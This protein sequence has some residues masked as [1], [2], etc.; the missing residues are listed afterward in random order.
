MAFPIPSPY[1][2]DSSFDVGNDH[3]N[4]QHKNLFTLIDALDKGRNEANFKALVDLVLLHFKEE[5]VHSQKIL[6]GDDFA[7][8]KTIHDNLV[9]TVGGLNAGAI[10]DEQ[11]A[12]LKNWLVNHIKGS[13]MK[14]KQ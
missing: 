9:S 1:V 10:G 5:E 4:E 12:F 13:D 2:W 14:Y 11:I 3:M 8:H 7:A 6:S